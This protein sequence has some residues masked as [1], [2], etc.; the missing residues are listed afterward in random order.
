MAILHRRELAWRIDSN[1]AASV[2]GPYTRAIVAVH[3]YGCR[4][5]RIFS[6]SASS[7]VTTMPPSPTAP[8][9]TYLPKI[10]KLRRQTARRYW[11]ALADFR[12]ILPFDREGSQHSYHLYVACCSTRRDSL[13]YLVAKGIVVGIHDATPGRSQP[14]HAGRLETHSL[15]NTETIAVQILSLPFYPELTKQQQTAVISAVSD[16]FKGRQ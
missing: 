13:E 15:T 8:K 4:R 9:F 7:L 3:L 6:A 11:E 10:I 1:A 5:K 16:F 12:L 14:A 2:V